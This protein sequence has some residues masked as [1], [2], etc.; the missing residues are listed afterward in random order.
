M[1]LSYFKARAEVMTYHELEQAIDFVKKTLINWCYD[2]TISETHLDAIRDE[3]HA[4]INEKVKRAANLKQL[5][6]G[7]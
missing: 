4:Y 6:M 2:K 3:Y 7:A 1:M 5:A